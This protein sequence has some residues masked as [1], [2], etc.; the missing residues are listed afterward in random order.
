MHV[1]VQQTCI[2]LLKVSSPTSSDEESI[3]RESKTCT[4]GLQKKRHAA[5][6]V[7]RSSTHFLGAESC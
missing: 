7:S 5:I 3:T 4:L 2:T 1:L 6:R